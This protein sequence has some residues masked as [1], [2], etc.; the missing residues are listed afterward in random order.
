MLNGPQDMK[1]KSIAL[2]FTKLFM[3]TIMFTIGVSM[4]INPQAKSYLTDSYIV[5]ILKM[6][7][8]SEIKIFG[9]KMM[10]KSG[11]EKNIFEIPPC[12]SHFLLINFT[13]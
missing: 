6:K 2:L 4:I 1:K 3:H 5:F 10:V 11:L 7:S 12:G 8:V 9:L 13:Y